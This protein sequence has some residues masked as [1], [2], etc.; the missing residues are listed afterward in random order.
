M[1]ER[2]IIIYRAFGIN[3]DSEILLP[4]LVVAG[5]VPDVRIVYGNTPRELVGAH[6]KHDRR[7][8]APDQ[9]LLNVAG[10]GRYYVRNGDYVVVEPDG[11]AEERE[12]RLFLLGSVMAALLMQRRIMPIHGSAVVLND[13]A[14][15]ITG[16]SG[17]GKSTLLGALRKCGA[18]YL[19]D[20]LAAV[21]FD[22]TGAPWV[23]SGYPQQKLW[24]DSALEMGVDISN[25]PPV[26]SGMDKYFVAAKEGFCQI[27]VRLAAVCELRA[28][29]R[30][31]AIISGLAGPE[32][33]AVLMRHTF[34]KRLLAGMGLQ[35]AHFKQC[36]D[37][38]AQIAVSRLVRP[39][40]KYTAADQVRLLEHMMM[41]II[42]E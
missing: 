19:T 31:E 35:A 21:T 24:R 41:G 28:E 38:A 36:A 32:K 23:Q 14:I 17:A 26:E 27:P 4:E 42:T 33:L 13:R 34:R 22:E 20:D 11:S 25:C 39:N 30:R 10:V 5:G 1:T 18:S 37:V 2:K 12:I 9:F 40:G 8:V 6:V 3:I 7:Q 16:G 29:E 15:I